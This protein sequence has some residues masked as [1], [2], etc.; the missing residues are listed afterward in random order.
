MSTATSLSNPTTRLARVVVALVFALTS[1]AGLTS[2]A[3][4]AVGATVIGRFVTDDGVP[5]DAI[6][7]I[8]FQNNV[9]FTEVTSGTD[10]TFEI[11]GVPAGSY[12]FSGSD[13]FDNYSN[14]STAVTLVDGQTQ[15]LGDIELSFFSFYNPAQQV[16]G[17]VRDPAGKPVRGIWVYLRTPAPLFSDSA[18]VATWITDRTG[19][20]ILDSTFGGTPF[21]DGTYKLYFTD[22]H[23]LE[24]DTFAYGDRSPATSRP[25]LGRRP[26]PS[27]PRSTSSRT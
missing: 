15:A 22:N 6:R 3:S 4:A 10:G 21:P 11:S 20:Y 5:L 26:S 24:T 18:I 8:L 14:S 27:T 1:L 25:G 19:R 12:F 17:F 9:I 16:T 13:W 2:P 7:A 23:T